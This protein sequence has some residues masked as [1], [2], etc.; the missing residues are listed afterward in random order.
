MLPEKI[1]AQFN[2]IVLWAVTPSATGD[3]VPNMPN[4]IIRVNLGARRYSFAK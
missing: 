2:G 4:K 1:A 3:F